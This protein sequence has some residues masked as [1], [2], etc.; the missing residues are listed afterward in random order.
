MLIPTAGILGATNP[1]RQPERPPWGGADR[2]PDALAPGDQY[3]HLPQFGDHIL[4]LVP[5]R[6]HPSVLGLPKRPY[7]RADHSQ[8][9]GSPAML[10][11]LD[12]GD[13]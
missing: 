13:L 10:G 5:L 11:R 6:S 8:G 3:V 9:G 4:R 7:L 2:V 1:E 12:P